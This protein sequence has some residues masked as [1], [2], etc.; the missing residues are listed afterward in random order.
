MH[1]LPQCL[2]KW[3][4]ISKPSTKCSC[5]YSER[6]ILGGLKQQPCSLPYADET[7]VSLYTLNFICN[8][9]T[10]NEKLAIMKENLCTKYFPFTYKYFALNKK[11]PIAKE[12]LHIF[13]FVIG[14]VEC[15]SYN[16]LLSTV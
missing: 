7:A 8:E 6:S 9:V 14:G 3:P 1:S 2:P 12:N 11:P 16:S 13:F 5:P 10:F 15:T 4:F